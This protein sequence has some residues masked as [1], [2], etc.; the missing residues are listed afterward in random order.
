VQAREH[1]KGV[2]PDKPRAPALE[3]R[4]AISQETKF[5]LLS[6]DENL[7]P[8]MSVFVVQIVMEYFLRGLEEH[9]LSRQ[10][11]KQTLV[12]VLLSKASYLSSPKHQETL[13][14]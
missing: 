14:L 4:S 7:L 2:S 13:R 5:L 11:E 10:A 6:Q 3:T 12:A 9:H 1:T 8:E